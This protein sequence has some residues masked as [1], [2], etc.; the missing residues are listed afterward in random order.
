MLCSL[1]TFG[2]GF[3]TLFEYGLYNAVDLSTAEVWLQLS[4][5]GLFITIMSLLTFVRVYLGTGLRWLIV[6][7]GVLWLGRI[8]GDIATTNSIMH[9]HID[10]LRVLV[11][12]W[13]ETYRMAVGLATP[14]KYLADLGSV[15]V[16]IFL[17]HATLTSLRHGLRRRAIIVGGSSITFILIAGILVPL[18]DAGIIEIP[19]IASAAFL[20]IIFAL[21]A[22]LINEA[23]HANESM[24]E[25]ERLRRAMTLG[26]M[27]GGLAHEINQPLT[28]ILSN[29]QAAARFLKADDPD[30]DEIREIV[31]DIIADEKNASGIIR[32]IRQMLERKDVETRS[33]DVNSVAQSAARIMSGELQTRAVS[34]RLDLEPSLRPVRADALQLQQVLLNLLLN[35]V[36]AAAEMPRQRRSVVLQT[37]STELG[38][39]VSVL[40]EGAGIPEARKATL[41]QPFVSFSKDGLGVGLALC[42]RIVER[43]GGKIWVED[44]NEGGTA[45]RF[46]LPFAKERS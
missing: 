21:A 4:T 18:Q 6:I 16:F 40:D 45:F 20:I 33:A 13:G 31:D 30:L 28:A 37:C 29:A 8:G 14:W 15:F 11:T 7:I 26:E 25:V 19:F 17:I 3:V 38:I 44:R 46:T 27:V 9:A 10:E 5:F 36:R 1:M 42:K 39:E 22:E 2:A 34:I 32:G 43:Y 35:A 12:P 41:F 24:L 23:Y